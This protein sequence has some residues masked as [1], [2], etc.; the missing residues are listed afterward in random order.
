M[1]ALRDLQAAFSAHLKGEDRPDLAASVVGDTISAAARLRVHRHH[2]AESLATALEATFPTVQAIVGDAFFRA[3]AKTFVM[4]DLPRQ[5]VLV[6]YGAGF[7]AFVTGYRPAAS[8]PYLADMARLD[9]ALNLA[10][11]APEEERLAPS[12][13]AGWAPERLLGLKLALAAGSGVILSP[14]PVDR[15]WRASQPG[16]L[17]GVSLEEGAA[18]VIV[19]RRSGDAVFERL[20]LSEAAFVMALDGGATLEEGAEAAYAV[21]HAFDL[22]TTFAQLLAFRA[23]AAVQQDPWPE[24]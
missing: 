8:L 13:L 4:E 16:S 18:A 5:P 23:F 20:S 3:M 22:S 15:I 12:D 1:P 19:L 2:V 9:W 10:L 11:Q 7:P 6:E 21:D 14:Y 24:S 17:E